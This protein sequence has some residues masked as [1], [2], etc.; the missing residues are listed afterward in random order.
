MWPTDTLTM[1]YNNVMNKIVRWYTTGHRTRELRELAAGSVS[2]CA[3]RDSNLAQ[4]NCNTY[5]PDN[6]L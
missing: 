5:R 6:V 1:C 4:S 2:H 3:A